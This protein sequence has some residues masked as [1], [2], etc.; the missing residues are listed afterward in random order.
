[1]ARLNSD[2]SISGTINGITYYRTKHGNFARRKR[3]VDKSFY[4]KDPRFEQQREHAATFGTMAKYGKLIRT[5]F[6]LLLINATD[7]RTCQK[8]NKILYPV[9]K[10]QSNNG[11]AGAYKSSPCL[12]ILEGFEFNAAFQVSN[13][14]RVSHQA[15]V[16]RQKGEVIINVLSFVP[17]ETV[18]IPS[19]ATFMKLSMGVVELDFPD[20]TIVSSE[21]ASSRCECT[22]TATDDFRLSAKFTAGS[23]HAVM[24]ALGISFYEQLGAESKLMYPAALSIIN[25]SLP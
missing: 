23:E 6:R 3:T 11:S 1:M 19:G 9:V 12:T 7:G 24:V 5:A 14:C 17:K 20:T 18:Q 16:D 25:V 8:M 4:A 22:A 2:L 21:V 15:E 13:V 10:A